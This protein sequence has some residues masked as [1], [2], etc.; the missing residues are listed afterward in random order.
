MPVQLTHRTEHQ[1]VPEA[2]RR[3]KSRA[4]IPQVRH[5]LPS[6]RTQTS[7]QHPTQPN[8][9]QP[10][11]RTARCNLGFA[12][13]L[14]PDRR[15]EWPHSLALHQP[16]LPRGAHTHTDTHS[17]MQSSLKYGKYSLFFGGTIQYNPHGGQRHGSANHHQPTRDLLNS[18]SLGC[19]RLRL[20]VMTT[21]RMYFILSTVVVDGWMEG[22]YLR[23]CRESP[24]VGE[25]FRMIQN[26]ATFRPRRV[27]I[28]NTVEI[29]WAN[30]SREEPHFVYFETRGWATLM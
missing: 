22:W 28:W 8:N 13:R 16:T 3:W 5:L 17:R 23:D 27:L 9:Q 1:A 30:L 10:T 12:L 20:T 7:E 15:T 2:N 4:K 29:F 11:T 18:R 21:P 25:G 26:L 6:R 14:S 24:D 19:E